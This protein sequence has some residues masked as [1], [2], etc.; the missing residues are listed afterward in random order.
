MRKCIDI[1]NIKSM[2]VGCR[3]MRGLPFTRKE[4]PGNQSKKRWDGPSILLIS[5]C[6]AGDFVSA[7]PGIC[8]VFA[9]V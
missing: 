6:Y 8:P 3:Y 5:K 7:D 4:D 1:Y 9:L 2:V